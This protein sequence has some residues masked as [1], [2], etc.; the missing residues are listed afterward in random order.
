MK[1]GI[2]RDAE[3]LA[4]FSNLDQQRD[5]DY[6]RN[7]YPEF[8]PK[9]FWTWMRAH[10]GVKDEPLY[11]WK[12]IQR[13]LREAWQTGFPLEKSIPL[14]SVRNFDFEADDWDVDP[15]PFQKAVMFLSVEPWRAR[16]CVCGKRFVADRP[17]RQYCCTKCTANA[18]KLSR[19]AWW[20]DHGKEWRAGRK[21][22]KGKPARRK[23]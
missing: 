20:G 18:R 4:M 10:A 2:F 7:N 21:Q 9:G 3:T 15:A 13:I 12:Q 17:T 8:M 19:R 1:W 11:V 22:S 6:F 16:F 14:V 5:V 23:R